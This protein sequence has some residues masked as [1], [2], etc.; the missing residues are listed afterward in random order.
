[1]KI[2]H[3]QIALPSD[4]GSWVFLLS[5]LLIGIF[6]AGSFT[7]ATLWLVVGALA[8]FLTRQPASMI[9]KAYSKRRS[10][11]ALPAAF[12]WLTGYG[13]VGLG[14][15]V[16]LYTNGFSYVLVLLIPGLLVFA[17]HLWLVSRRAERQ[18]MGVDIV[19]SG[20]LAV[21]APAAYWIGVG[22]PD[23][24]GWWL[25]GLTWFQSAASIVYAFLRL[26]QR[27]LTAAPSRQEKLRLGKR[28]LLYTSFNSIAVIL[29][30]AA[31]ILP[32]LLFLPYV[33]QLAETIWGTLNPAIG[34]KPT[35]I[36]LRQLGVSAIFT[37]LFILTWN[38][39]LA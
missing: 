8:A 5:P 11:K 23:A 2:F 4:H 28:A 15:L 37:I 1:M 31:D 16:E 24:L 9:V 21:S 12:F 7:T 10:R 38:I 35:Q 36:G 19:A 6:A 34:K 26:E 30:S 20:A 27:K 13:L 14:A 17:W 39:H 25:W 22:S 32:P 3:R 18:Q 33:L 29:C